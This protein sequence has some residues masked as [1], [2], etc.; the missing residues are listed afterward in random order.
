MVRSDVDRVSTCRCW[1]TTTDE[2]QAYLGSVAGSLDVGQLRRFVR[3]WHEV[4]QRFG[5]ERVVEADAALAAAVQA[6]LVEARTGAQP[7]E[8]KR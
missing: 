4:E 8:R 3:A 5:A 2:L 6:L 1:N 7:P